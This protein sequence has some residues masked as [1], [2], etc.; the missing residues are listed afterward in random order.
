[1]LIISLPHVNYSFASNPSNINKKKPKSNKLE[2]KLPQSKPQ[3]LTLHPN[4]IV[5]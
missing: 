4:P 2:K 1:M 5:I 3:S